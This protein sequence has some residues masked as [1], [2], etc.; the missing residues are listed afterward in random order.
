MEHTIFNVKMTLRYD[1]DHVTEAEAQELF[2]KA[3]TLR[4]EPAIEIW[5]VEI[6]EENA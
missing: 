2:I 5:G 1:D 3:V 4:Y 6:I